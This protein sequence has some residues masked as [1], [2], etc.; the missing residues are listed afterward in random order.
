[1][2][3]FN[4]RIHS[5]AKKFYERKVQKSGRKILV[6]AVLL[7]L[8][9]TFSIAYSFGYWELLLA[10]LILLISIGLLTTLPVGSKNLALQLPKRIYTDGE[11]ITS[12]S[13][14]DAETRFL[15]DVKEVRDYG[16]FY[17]LV[18]PFG[19]ISDRFVCQKELLS[20]GTI[21]E[22]EAMFESKIVRM[23]TQS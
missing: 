2:I 19:K 3:E 20:Q 18:F 14:K 4:G 22:F 15:S 16:T 17:D 5:D 9:G 7:F 8:P 1:M 12:V 11:C 13:E 21:E 23:H 6:I 10:H